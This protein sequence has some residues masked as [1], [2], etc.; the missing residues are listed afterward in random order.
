MSE[1]RD[2]SGA[3]LGFLTV[4]ECA[5]RG[6][7]G[8][9]LVLNAAG[10]PI[11]FHCTAPVKPNRAQEILYGATLAPYLYGEQIGH[12]LV[13]QAKDNPTLLCTDCEEM[14]SL[15]PH[16]K[17]PVVLIEKAQQER[18]T[19]QA[20]GKQLRVDAAHA[21]A[22]PSA[23]FTAGAHRVALAAE[24]SGDQSRVTEQLTKLPPNFDL[25]EP[26]ERIRQAIAE[27]GGAR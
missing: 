10:R 8:G 11:Q 2:K 21:P 12:T 15:A 19:A 1:V 16:V 3:A 4:H 25:A 7:F 23:M 22:A 5:T 18:T 14:F 20:E 27:A 6:L 24:Y 13:S 17:Q 26:F 9:Y